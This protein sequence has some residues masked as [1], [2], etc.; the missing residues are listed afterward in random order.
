MKKR[1]ICL[2]IMSSVVL[3]GC[4]K[5]ESGEATGTPTGV[6]TYEGVG[7]GYG[8]EVKVAV[9]MDGQTITGIEVVE[10]HETAP[11][12]NR[13][14]P[15]I[16]DR[17]VEAKT[18]VVDSVSGATFTSFAVKSAVADALTQAGVE[19]EKI[20]MDTK[21][22]EVEKKELEEV[23]T[24]LV[25]VGSFAVKSAVADALTQAGVEVEKISMDTKGPEVE[26][27][28]LEEV[29]TQLVIVGGGPA[30]LSAAIEAKEN[31]VEDVIL[32][33]KL[34]ILSGNGK[35]DM[36][37][38][39]IINTEAQKANGVEDSVEKFIEDK[40]DSVVD[41]IERL[42]A[43][44][45]GAA[46]V[47]FDIINTEAQKANGVED[48]VEKFIEDKKDSV[49]DSIE[50]L[51]AQANGAA[52]V[53]SWLRG[54]GINL[55]YN[56]G[57]RNHMAEADAYAGEHIQDNL[58]KKVQELGVDV[59][60][61]TKGLDL[62]MEDGKA[63]GI[64][65]E[66]KEGTYDIKADAVI[67]AT[68]GFSHN[69]ELLAEYAPGAE[70]LATSNQMG[71]TG[72]FVSVFQDHADAVIVATGGFSHNKEL[73]AEYAP[74]AERLATSNQM[75]ATGDF[76]SVFQDHNIKMDH[77]DKLSVFKLIISGRRDLTGAGDG[78]LL[79]NKAGERFVDESA[80]SMEVGNA[81]LDQEGGKAFYIYDQR[82]YDSSY[83][84]KKHNDLGYHV[85]V[86]VLHLWM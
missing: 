44:A 60:T 33:E 28:E 35:F 62:I 76:V 61:G 78:F 12:S 55:N 3:A 15:I 68:G 45:N 2:L 73:L 58:E 41:S 86:K 82:L 27:K 67:V 9:E 65:V 46:E 5:T 70:R 69:K 71:A 59:R 36:N 74:G 16:V 42:T 47:F 21:G 18:P 64:K 17:I 26:K 7:H 20:S 56:Y 32:V 8:G 57:G 10:H 11:V 25:I 54:M 4:A 38:F 52:E 19:V 75:G 43:Q 29:K 37:F 23:K 13:A 40:K 31:G 66:C 79:V 77:M 53:D 24:Q 83:R 30:G 39:D 80:A 63:T 6:A 72:D 50:R 1:L 14:L 51:T 84:L 34:D 81:I 22:P 49:V 85:K 48:S